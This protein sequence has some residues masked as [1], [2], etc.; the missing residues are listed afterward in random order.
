MNRIKFFLSPFS[1]V[2]GMV[3]SVRNTCFDLGILKQYASKVPLISVGNLSM[4][5]T[6]KTPHVAYISAVLSGKKIAVISRGY[7]R[8]NTNLILG[9]TSIHSTADIGDEPME[10]L[11]KFEGENFKML[12]EADRKKALQ[13]IEQKF[14]N[15]KLV[16]LDDGFQHRYVKRTLNLLLTDYSKLFY[17]DYIVPVGT[18]RESRAGA[19][20]ADVIV[21]TKCNPSISFQEKNNIKMHL[22]KY[23]DA[24]VYFS[25]IEYKGFKNEHGY[26][27]DPSKTYLVITGIAKPDP[28]FKH[29]SEQS[30]SFESLTFSDHHN[31]SSTDLNKI[32]LKSK[33]FSGII[34]TE[35]D[36]M[37]LKE[38]KLKELSSLEIYRLEIGITIVGE[39][40]ALEFEKL[41]IETLK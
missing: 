37:R 15:T 2:Y 25:K 12:V 9:D 26:L 28:I 29:L 18:L 24:M 5:G 33:A 40:E 14:P 23:T 19:K 41:I 31:F 7:G 21:V 13:Y 34:T 3:T 38:T 8:T 6:G 32:V 20:R 39:T 16:I 10:L 30:I 36:W 4:G 27:L 22:A 11:K 1:F 17:N 35:K